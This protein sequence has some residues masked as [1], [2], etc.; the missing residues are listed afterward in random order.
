MRVEDLAKV[1]VLNS[2]FRSRDAK[3]KKDQ[4]TLDQR[5]S[6]EGIKVESHKL[7]DGKD[8]ENSMEEAKRT[9]ILCDMPEI[10]DFRGRILRLGSRE[11]SSLRILL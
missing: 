7:N 2:V 11:N 3:V 6:S 4:I 8:S 10:Y 5:G 1:G 9:E